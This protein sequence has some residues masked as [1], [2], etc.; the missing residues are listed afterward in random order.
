MVRRS[1]A[2][3]A[4][5]GALTLAL[6]VSGC[7]PLGSLPGASAGPAESPGA[8]E[9]RGWLGLVTTDV[10]FAATPATSGLNKGLRVDIL[11]PGAPAALTGIRVNDVIILFGD[12]PVPSTNDLLAAEREVGASAVD[13]VLIRQGE[14]VRLRA[15]LQ[16]PPED[17]KL[18]KLTQEALLA[19]LAR[20]QQAA[21]NAQNSGDSRSAFVHYA[22]CLRLNWLGG[23]YLSSVGADF[24]EDLAKVAELLRELR[25]PPTPSE[26]DRHNRLAIEILRHATSDD[27]NDRAVREFQAAIIEAPWIADLYL[28]LGLA[29][30]KA[31][32]PEFALQS[33]HEYQILDPKAGEAPAIKDKLAQLEVLPEER[34]PWLPFVGTWTTNDG[35]LLA[36]RLRDLRL[37]ITVVK[38]G[39]AHSGLLPGDVLY[40]GDVHGRRFRGK[41]H[42]SYARD[43]DVR[44]LGTKR[45]WD[46]KG[47]I[48]DDGMLRFY[49]LDNI[50]YDINSCQISSQKWE[51]YLSFRGRH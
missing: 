45:L 18:R 40:S 8:A 28:N 24:H 49:A 51:Q 47:A 50:T 4:A 25:P 48:E 46:A 3:F 29:A 2:G 34:K 41:F 21:V 20:E 15:K 35:G 44:C 12:K 10:E 17:A 42:A 37:V 39:S 26:A 32:A 6:L 36:I 7:A 27:D 23:A 5:A 16:P 33:L 38:P 22:T 19:R 30:A 14:R 11:I 31:G 43:N 9:S 1:R 13:I